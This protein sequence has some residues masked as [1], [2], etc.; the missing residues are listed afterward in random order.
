[1]GS[2]V[3][4]R[5]QGTV[6]L[7]QTGQDHSRSASVCAPGR[8][9]LLFGQEVAAAALHSLGTHCFGMTPLRA[10]S[11]PVFRWPEAG[12]ALVSVGKR[13]W[14]L[15]TNITRTRIDFFLCGYVR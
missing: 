6:G 3:A 2:E 5:I 13:E 8:Q 7:F 9:Y 14:V 10:G 11:R 12:K 4:R 1:M 15:V